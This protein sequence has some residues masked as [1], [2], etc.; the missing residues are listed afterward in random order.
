M[1]ETS[2]I[3]RLSQSGIIETVFSLE[4]RSS[5]IKW[6][7]VFFTPRHCP[8]CEI[9]SNVACPLVVSLNFSKHFQISLNSNNQTTFITI[10]LLLS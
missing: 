10:V 2:I 8:S 7:F 3:T 5:S 4:V 9:I 1:L 6:P